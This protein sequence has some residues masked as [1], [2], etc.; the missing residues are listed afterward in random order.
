MG[1]LQKWW[2]MREALSAVHEGVLSVAW[3]AA[4]FMPALESMDTRKTLVRYSH[5]I[6]ELL[7]RTPDEESDIVS[8]GYLNNSEWAM[9][10]GDTQA[11][12]IIIH[13]MTSIVLRARAQGQIIV[14]PDIAVAQFIAAFNDIKKNAQ[15]IDMLV[16]TAD[17]HPL[18]QLLSVLV[19]FA[20]SMFAMEMGQNAGSA[21][22]HNHSLWLVFDTIIVFVVHCFYQVSIYR[23]NLNLTLKF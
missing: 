17:A 22:L 23:T 6:Y 18:T 15:K 2:A 10:K 12:V 1:V 9:I 20:M 14:S 16:N 8:L 5:A 4:S 13:W 7:W 19:F 3:T 21:Q 11:N